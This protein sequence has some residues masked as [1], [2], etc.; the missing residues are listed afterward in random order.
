MQRFFKNMLNNTFKKRLMLPLLIMGVLVFSSFI[1]VIQI[2]IMTLN[3]AVIY[4]LY[5]AAANDEIASSY[6]VIINSIMSIIGLTIFYLSQKKLWEISSAIFTVLFLLPLMILVF[7]FIETDIYFLRDL[8]SGF[9]VGLVLIAVVFLK[10]LI[11]NA[12]FSL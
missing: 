12:G 4:P 2:L 1:P 7:G 10:T 8:I 5:F 11:R 3:G 9:V 6:I